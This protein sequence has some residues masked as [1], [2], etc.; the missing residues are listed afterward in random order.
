MELE[1]KADIDVDVDVDVDG[2]IDKLVVSCK[3]D[4]SAAVDVNI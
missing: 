3:D 4:T 2:D 1:S